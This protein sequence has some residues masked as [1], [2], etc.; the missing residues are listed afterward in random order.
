MDSM[1]HIQKV[2]N[3]R[4]SGWAH[5]AKMCDIVLEW[6]QSKCSKILQIS[7]SALSNPPSILG[8]GGV[9]LKQITV[10]TFQVFPTHNQDTKKS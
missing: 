3:K 2:W 1:I 9:T 7:S 5:K 6:L 4:G 10:A 8:G